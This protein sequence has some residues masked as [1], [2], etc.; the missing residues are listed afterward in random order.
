MS[1]CE[2]PCQNPGQI[3]RGVIKSLPGSYKACDYLAR[4]WQG[5]DKACHYLVSPCEVVT[6]LVTTL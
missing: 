2:E 3:L 1:K 6:K 5:S 4:C